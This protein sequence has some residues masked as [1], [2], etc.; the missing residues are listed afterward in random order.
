MLLLNVLISLC[1]NN[2]F[3]EFHTYSI[4]YPFLSNNSNMC[5][6]LI[7]CVGHVRVCLLSELSFYVLFFCL[8]S[9]LSCYTFVKCIRG[10]VNYEILKPPLFRF[11]QVTFP[12]L[13]T[14][15]DHFTQIRQI[16]YS[17]FSTNSCNICLRWLNS[18]KDSFYNYFSLNFY[19]SCFDSG[20]VKFA[21]PTCSVFSALVGRMGKLSWELS[22]NEHNTIMTF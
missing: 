17:R 8:Y 2:I 18:T 3:Y 11:F 20:Y 22:K 1:F 19:P 5:R 10:V 14:F 7:L 6:S 21:F 12:A 13:V 15:I 9:R 4:I 16:D